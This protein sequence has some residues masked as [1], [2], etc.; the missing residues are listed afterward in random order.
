[1]ETSLHRQ[2]KEIYA[3]D[4]ARLEAQVERFRIDVVNDGELIEIQHGSLAAIRDKVQRLLRRH[5]VRVVKPIVVRKQLVK[6]DAR[7]GRVLARRQSPRQGSALDVFDE[8]VYFTRVFPHGNLS[9]DVPLVEI[10]EWR[11]PGH[12]RRRRWRQNDHQIE[13]QRLVNVQRVHRLVAARDLWKLLPQKLP[14][15]FHTGHLAEAAGVSRAIAQR[16]VYCL[17]HAGAAETIGKQGNT[18][19]YR[20]PPQTPPA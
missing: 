4:Q 18:V 5:R 7:G 17:R 10:E 14:R 2:L 9:L 3:G 19:L 20:R 1:M 12:G 16:I 13:D 11:F 15:R 6:Q 8:L